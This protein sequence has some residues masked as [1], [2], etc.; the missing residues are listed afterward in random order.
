[1]PSNPF[2]GSI[3]G[4]DE[5]YAYE[6]RNPWRWSFDRSTGQLVCGDVG[7]GA[8]EEID[9]ITNGGNFGWR[10]MEGFICNP[11]INSSCTPPSGHV[12]PIFDYSHASGR[13]SITGGYVYRGFRS[14]VPV[15]AYVYADYCTGEI[16][17]LQSGTNT[18]L[19]DTTLNITSFGEDEAGEVYVVG[20][21][22]TI[23]RLAQTPAPPACI[24]SLAASGR[25]A[26]P[27]G[28]DAALTLTTAGDCGWLAATS[29]GWISLTRTNGA[30]GGT[31]PFTV[32]PN[33]TG[34]PRTGLIHVGGQTFTVLQ[35]GVTS[36]DCPIRVEPLY[37]S[38]LSS[39]GTGSFT[40]TVETRCAWQAVASASWITITSNSLGTGSG[41]VTYSVAANSTGKPRTG[42]I[43]FGKTIFTV[44]QKA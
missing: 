20:Q 9:I 44:K 23:N 32:A 8:R 12:L 21:N 37:Q 27:E 34:V 6:L 1:P 7:Q 17:Q 10:I 38:F 39:G 16:W 13:C 41:T 26:P 4:A 31:L 11:D 18:L 28:M 19:M 25:L 29:V 15:S 40:V 5:I 24:Y 33:T 42:T 14:T 22:G 30:G 43:S 35:E 2:I 3:P 36:G